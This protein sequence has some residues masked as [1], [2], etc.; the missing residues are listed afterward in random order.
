MLP[1][2]L[3]I[4]PNPKVDP[5][6]CEPCQGP[7]IGT[8]PGQWVNATELQAYCGENVLGAIHE[9]F[10]D[11]FVWAAR[12]CTYPFRS[13][14]EFLERFDGAS[15]IFAGDSTVSFLVKAW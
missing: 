5:R 9:W 8:L 1:I 4:L 14:A 11:D 15:I 13:R 7:D 6:G 3:T 2:E 12:Q 10:E